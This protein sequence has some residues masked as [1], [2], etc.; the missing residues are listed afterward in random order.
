MLFLWVYYTIILCLILCLFILNKN[1]NFLILNKQFN[2]KKDIPNSFY[3]EIHKNGYKLLHIGNIT[4]SPEEEYS[5]PIILDN[6]KRIFVIFLIKNG[7]IFIKN[8]KFTKNI[9]I[10]YVKHL[11]I[12]KNITIKQ[13]Y[14]FSDL[15]N[16]NE[17]SELD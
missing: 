1:E 10:N 9:K 2:Y 7:I 12:N 5:L 16:N 3:E 11:T 15:I 14:C 17:R 13:D 6:M 4:R 8:I